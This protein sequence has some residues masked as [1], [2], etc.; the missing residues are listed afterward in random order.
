MKN[1]R[2]TGEQIIEAIKA[3][4]VGEK[5]AGICRRPGIAEGRFYHW[6]WKCA[7]MEFN[8]AKN[9]KLKKLLADKP[10]E[11]ETMKDVLSKKW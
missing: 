5:V 10:L 2:Y 6:R 11:I 9:S 3:H 7:G 8:Q 4:G 1:K